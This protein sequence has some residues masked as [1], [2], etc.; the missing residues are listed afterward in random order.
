MLLISYKLRGKDIHKIID[1][2]HDKG[3]TPK[4]IAREIETMQL[5]DESV[6]R[7]E[8]KDK[9]DKLRDCYYY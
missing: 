3:Y 1:D 4:E 9:L 8:M 6:A 5:L 2:L 7:K